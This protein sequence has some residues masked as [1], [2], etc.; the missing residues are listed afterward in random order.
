MLQAHLKTLSFFDVAA[1]ARVFCISLLEV[2]KV[3]GRLM[4]CEA[5]TIGA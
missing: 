1:L 4:C 5:T 3:L 2:C